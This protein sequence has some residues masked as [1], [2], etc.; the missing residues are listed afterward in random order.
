MKLRTKIQVYLSVFILIIM[1]LV[2]T[3]VYFLFYK[4]ATE[5]ELEQLVAQTEL[6]VE[7]LAKTTDTNEVSEL[8]NAFLPANGMVQVFAND[9]Q[10]LE[11]KHR[12]DAYKT[13]TGKFQS[14]ETHEILKPERGINVAVVTRPII[15]QD[16]SV[17]TLQLSN[18]LV[19]LSN[20]L[21]I[22][23]YVLLFASLILLIPTF[24]GGNILIRFLL[25]PIHQLTQAMKENIKGRK[26]RKI[27]L[28]NRSKDELYEMEATFNDMIDQL[29]DNY[30]KQEDFVS[31]ASH[32]LKTP[33]QI[34]KSYAQLIERRGKDNEALIQESVEAIDSEADRMQKLVEQLLA[35]AKSKREAEHTKVE[36]VQLVDHS[37]STFKH[38]YNREIECIKN[39]ESIDVK[40]NADQLEQIIYILIDNALKYS[41]KRIIVSLFTHNGDVIFSVKDFGKGISKDE[42]ERIFERFY[43]VDKARS[44]ETGG[45]GLGLA[46][47]KSI[48]EEHQGELTIDS[49]MGEGSTFTLVLP[50]LREE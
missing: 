6:L 44:R 41:E 10:T 26:W 14:E 29:K 11:F 2:N 3:S 8:M 4:N 17:V 15:W 19:E 50:I 5:S 28:T 24:I 33:I 35:L 12:E 20:T 27:D 30:E 9:G 43:R 16:G 23:F 42:Q 48:T 22:L 32:E 39:M 38:A 25:N 45:T 21:T 47:A 34:V 13:L 37:V 31:N 49:V 40:G 18:N 1:L 46:I 36:L 7:R